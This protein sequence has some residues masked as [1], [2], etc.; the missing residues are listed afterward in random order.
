[1]STG[2]PGPLPGGGAPSGGS[3]ADAALD[4]LASAPA[5]RRR[6][7]ATSDLSVDE[8]VALAHAGYEPQE[9]VMGSSI[10]HVGWVFG[11]GAK[12]GELVQL[13]QAMAAA[14]ADALAQLES[15]ARRAGAVGVV[16]VRMRAGRFAGSLMEFTAVGTAVGPGAGA[17]REPRGREPRGRGLFT[18]G[19]SGQELFLLEQAGWAPVG[20]V[21]GSCVWQIGFRWVPMNAPNQELQAPTEALYQTRERAMDRLQREAIALGADGVVGASLQESSHAWGAR[22]VESV[23]MGTAVVRRSARHRPLGVRGVLPLVD[24]EPSV[25]AAS[26]RAGGER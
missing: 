2:S 24:A 3:L 22:A 20:L 9:L 11:P 18:S 6:K 23:A 21:A 25:D 16:G 15:D 5:G 19:L 7:V 1:M 10:Y 14:R 12:G 17:Q 13:S 26:L 4:A 8:A